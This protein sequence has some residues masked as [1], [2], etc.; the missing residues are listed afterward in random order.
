MRLVS[1]W[2]AAPAGLH[3]HAPAGCAHVHALPTVVD[4]PWSSPPPLPPLPPLLLPLL[5]PPPPPVS[6]AERGRC[7]CK[8]GRRAAELVE[9]RA[10]RVVEAALRRPPPLATHLRLGGSTGGRQRLHS[11]AGRRVPAQPPRR[12][13]AQAQTHGAGSSE[14][15]AMKE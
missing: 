15:A 2:A 13:P 8:A 3:T 1:V 12:R 9:Y 10:A 7:S 11:G 6:D 14:G 5:P 4:G